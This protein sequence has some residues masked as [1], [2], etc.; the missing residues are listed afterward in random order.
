MYD[1][2]KV[3]VGLALFVGLTTFPVWYNVASGEA[4]PR[5]ELT[6]GTSEPECVL[7]KET[8]LAEHPA[9]LNEWRNAAVR[10]G[11]RTYTRAD[12]RTIRRSLTGTCLGCHAQKEQFC[13]ACHGY[14]AVEPT[15]WD[16]HLTPAGAQ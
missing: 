1:A 6:L 14:V 15:C 10:D 12:D 3:V 8:M 13:D 16:C 4:G 2:G 5:P 11:Q 9:L 7:P